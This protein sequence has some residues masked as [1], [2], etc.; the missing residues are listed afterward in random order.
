VL[1]LGFFDGVH[2]GHGQLFK[3]AALRAKKLG[4]LA[5]ALTYDPHP[6]TLITGRPVPLL[7]STDE[8]AALIRT[9]YRIPEVIVD[10]FDAETAQIPW[11]DYVELVIVRRLRAVHVVAGHDF[12]FGRG[13]EGT[14]ALLSEAC[15]RYGVGCDILPPKRIAGTRV[16]S[17]YIRGLVAEGDMENAARFLGHAYRLSG[18]VE[19]GQGLGR[20]LGF[21]TANLPLPKERQAPAWGVYATRVVWNGRVYPA[22]TNVGIRPTMSATSAPTAESTLLGFD[23]DLYGQ[24]IDVDFVSFIRPEKRFPSP[25][26][27]AQQVRKDM[28]AAKLRG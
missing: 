24:R 8:R 11:Q 9:M 18:T 3:R 27:L 15:R 12:T 23:G 6:Q 19:R 21:P 22:A 13:G 28:E 16:S 25:E 14:P 4:C 17:T 7:C 10:P 26:A 2:I 1:A 5:C 20:R